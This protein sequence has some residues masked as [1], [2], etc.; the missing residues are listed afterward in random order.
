MFYETESSLGQCPNF[1]KKNYEVQQQNQELH[2]YQGA[3]SNAG[4][5]SNR[6]HAELQQ[7]INA[8]SHLENEMKARSDKQQQ[9]VKFAQTEQQAA[10]QANA[11]TVQLQATVSEMQVQIA[12]ATAFVQRAEGEHNESK[13]LLKEEN[14]KQRR[15]HK[16]R[17]KRNGSRMSMKRPRS[18]KNSKNCKSR[19]QYYCQGS[20]NNHQR[21]K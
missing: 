15:K 7:V 9:Y 8:K 14:Q 18:E 19:W 13:R 12:N 3:L 21:S 6:R 11:S 17:W 10:A 20:Q 2:L 16:T 5:D 1:K 4:G